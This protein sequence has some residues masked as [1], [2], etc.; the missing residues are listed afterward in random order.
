MAGIYNSKYNMQILSEYI[1]D[2]RVDEN[3]TQCN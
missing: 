3:L 2:K 1:I